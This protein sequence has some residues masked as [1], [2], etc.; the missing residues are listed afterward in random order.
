[1]IIKLKIEERGVTLMELIIYVAI[2]MIFVTGVVS[3]GVQLIGVRVKAKVQ[4]EVIFNSRMISDRIA[5]EIRN[6]SA[7]NSVSANSISLAYLDATRNPTII[8][9]SG[10]RLTIGW[11]SGAPCP[12]SSPCF[13]TSSNTSVGSVIFTN[14]SDGG[15]K[16]ASIKYSFT[17]NN[18][19]TNGGSNWNYSQTING[20]AEIKSK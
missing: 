14:M 10:N 9:K 20:N 13:L 18:I 8:A 4:Q 6:A 15:G 1:M 3:F 5:L 17:I 16:S 7:I 12:T 2:F 11:G 19:N